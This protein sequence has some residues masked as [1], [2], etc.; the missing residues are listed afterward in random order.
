MKVALN[1]VVVGAAE[2][3]VQ[4]PAHGPINVM[5]PVEPYL[6]LMED[7]LNR[8]ALERRG[9]DWLL[10]WRKLNGYAPPRSKGR[11]SA[12][13]SN[14]PVVVQGLLECLSAVRQWWMETDLQ[15][16]QAV[17]ADAQLDPVANR[18]RHAI[19]YAV[20][21]ANGCAFGSKRADRI[22]GALNSS[23]ALGDEWVADFIDRSPWK[24]R[25]TVAGRSRRSAGWWG[26]GYQS[27]LDEAEDRLEEVYASITETGEYS[28]GAR[29]YR[30]VCAE[31]AR[32]KLIELRLIDLS[33][34]T[35]LA[36]WG[37]R[38]RLIVYSL[39]L[40]DYTSWRDGKPSDK[41][42]LLLYLRNRLVNHLAAL[43]NLGLDCRDD[44]QRALEWLL[45]Q[46]ER[47][48]WDMVS[49]VG[50]VI[51]INTGTGEEQLRYLEDLRRCVPA[52]AH[53]S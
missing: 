3:P 30:S 41:A 44:G 13:I 46:A 51:R 22:C 12:V 23:V 5:R 18:E 45:R 19:L 4:W 2:A 36:T 11:T 42:R 21:N 8:S 33:Y 6:E 40:E 50:D 31:S 16:L 17:R 1:D 10:C 20:L 43:R 27:P 34:D 29:A 47:I 7:P 37:R 52:K 49:N 35:A 39:G 38:A 9:E 48:R 26:D 14:D 28:L 15:V 24:A 25:L 32:Y 53:Q